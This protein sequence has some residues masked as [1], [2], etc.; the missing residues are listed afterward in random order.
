M[1]SQCAVPENIHTSP[2]KGIGISWGVDSGGSRGPNDLKK[3]MKPTVNFQRGGGGGG[4]SL[5]KNI[6]SVGEVYMDMF[7]NYTTHANW[8]L[9]E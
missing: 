9:I 6:L 3:C 8:S 1:D 4:E 5:R 2:K 7:W